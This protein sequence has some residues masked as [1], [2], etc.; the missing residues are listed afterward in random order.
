MALSV[1]ASIVALIAFILLAAFLLFP[2]E[3]VSAQEG[4]CNG[5]SILIKGG[6][7]TPFVI[8]RDEGDTLR[9]QSDS[10]LLL[11]L[12]NSKT[13][14]L[15]DPK[16]EVRVLISG[17][18]LDAFTREVNPDPNSEPTIVTLGDEIPS[19]MRGLY[20]VEGTLKDGERNIC[21]VAF[22]LRVGEFGGV[23]ASAA[24]ATSAVA[25]VGALASA[26]LASNGMNAK[27]RLKVKFRRR[28]PKGWRRLLPVPAWKRT[29]FST[30]IGAITGLALAVVL[31]QAGVTPLSITTGIWALI[32]GGGVT[33]G[34]GYSL[35]ALRTYLRPPEVS[36]ERAQ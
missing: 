19:A 27:L 36:E 30:L 11:S 18:K 12:A 33:F 34:V 6:E 10:P 17:I 1:T 5:A 4:A 14:P 35:G 9:V 26:P 13:R 21:T 16:I 24:T 25:G 2:P 28:R 8:P 31:Q 23:V 20:D 15:Q 7:P 29:V 22:Q 3:V 32:V